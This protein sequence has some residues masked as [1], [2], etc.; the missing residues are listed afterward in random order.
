MTNLRSEIDYLHSILELLGEIREGLGRIEDRLPEKAYVTTV[1][2]LPSAEEMVK[3][4]APTV[5][6]TE[7]NQIQDAS[8]SLRKEEG[9]DENVV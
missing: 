7:T 5:Y 9:E 1:N 3:L 8:L 4:I 6:G 2:K